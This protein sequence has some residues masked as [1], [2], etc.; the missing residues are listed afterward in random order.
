MSDLLQS[1]KLF[2]VSVRLTDASN[3]LR[4]IEDNEPDLSCQESL[5]WAGRFLTEVD[6]NSGVTNQGI[7]GGL[8]VS[9]TSARPKFYAAIN[10]IAPRFKDVGINSENDLSA[11]FKRVYSLLNSGGTQEDLGTEELRLF[12][13]LLYLLSQSITVELSNNGLPR[14]PSFLSV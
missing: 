8:A 7:E 6:W 14:N 2:E 12:E 9:A 3:C 11:Y 1:A 4:T 10:R 5:K 13:D